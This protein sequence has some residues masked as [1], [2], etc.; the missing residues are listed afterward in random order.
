MGLASGGSLEQQHQLRPFTVQEIALILRQMLDALHYLH[1]TLMMSHRDVKPANILC[2]D[3]SHYRLA[4]FGLAKKGN[5]HKTFKCGTQPYKAPEMF[6]ETPYTAAVDIWALGMVAAR[7]LSRGW[8]GGYSG[9]EG[10]R[11][12]AAVV[13]HFEKYIKRSEAANARESERTRLN[14][15]VGQHMLKIKPEERK[16]ASGCIELLD[17]DSDN[18]SS[19][20]PQAHQNETVPNRLPKREDVRDQDLKEDVAEAVTDMRSLTTNEWLSLEREHAI[21][22]SERRLVPEQFLDANFTDDPKSASE[23]SATLPDS[24]GR[25][26][27]SQRK[28]NASP[29]APST[30]GVQDQSKKRKWSSQ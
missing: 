28:Q 18:D 12:C 29:A 5:A 24:E 16:S 14:N 22:E 20:I 8:P 21:N 2:D 23:H 17:R 13:A 10:P 30:T 27:P 3:R 25:S 26:E 1:T 11:W 4:D 15:L 6:T 19:T 7:F 9:E